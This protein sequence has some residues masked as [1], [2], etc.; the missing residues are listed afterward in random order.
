ML[1]T[2]E[3]V[4]TYICGYLL[5]CTFI[6][7]YCDV[8]ASSAQKDCDVELSNLYSFFKTYKSTETNNFGS[9][10]ISSIVFINYIKELHIKFSENFEIFIGKPNVRNNFLNVLSTVQFCHSCPDFPRNYLIQFYIRIKIFYILKFINRK[11]RNLKERNRKTI[12]LNHI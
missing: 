9:L 4:L 5:R 11:F 12:I 8:C 10:Y 3:N 1:V 2:E 7:H 6:K